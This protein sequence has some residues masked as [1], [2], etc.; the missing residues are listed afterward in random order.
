MDQAPINNQ[1]D[2]LERNRVKPMPLHIVG[3]VGGASAAQFVDESSAST[4]AA[5]KLAS[6]ALTRAAETSSSK[7]RSR[8]RC[9][10]LPVRNTSAETHAVAAVSTS[11][12]TCRAFPRVVTQ[13][14]RLRGETARAI[15]IR[16]S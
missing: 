2:D 8:I 9:T 1:R 14:P 3:V 10:P 16:T 5:R 11:L 13:I 6:H 4:P 7:R 12:S 15:V